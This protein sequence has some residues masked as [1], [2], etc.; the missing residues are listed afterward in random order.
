MGRGIIRQDPMTRS[1]LQAM[2]LFQLKRLASRLEITG[3]STMSKS[4]LI[5]ALAGRKIESRRVTRVKKKAERPERVRTIKLEKA[6][7]RGQSKQ[8][9]QKVRQLEQKAKRIEQ[10]ATIAPQPPPSE[11]MTPSQPPQPYGFSEPEDLPHLYHVNGMALMPRDPNWLFAYWEITRE[12]FDQALQELRTSAERVRTVLRI[13]DV[14]GRVDEHG[15]AVTSESTVVN[16]VDL[17]PM[18]SNWY[19]R[20]DR[21]GH[22]YCVEC[23]LLGPDGRTAVLARS[24][25][26]ATPWDRVSDIVDEEWVTSEM[27]NH[28]HSRSEHSKWLRERENGVGAS[29]ATSGGWSGSVSRG[30]RSW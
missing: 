16:V 15:S 7:P 29:T 13:H 18:S 25:V 10:E 17:P 2:K 28:G 9:E 14:T 19:I 22:L 24:N 6:T 4:E 8:L 26:A 1:E 5:D 12:K 27:S 11:I 21:P 20:V 23:L 3:R 30:P